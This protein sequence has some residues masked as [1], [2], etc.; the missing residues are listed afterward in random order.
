MF[1]AQIGIFCK[2]YHQHNQLAKSL[3]QD[4]ICQ[5]QTRCCCVLRWSTSHFGVAEVVHQF[6]P[7]QGMGDF[8]FVLSQSS[9]DSKPVQSHFDYPTSIPLSTTSTYN[10]LCL[11]AYLVPSYLH[12]HVFTLSLCFSCVMG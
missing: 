2:W 6:Q 11:C 7:H 1:P 10:S 3:N 12:S 8:S 4:S 9:L 5:L